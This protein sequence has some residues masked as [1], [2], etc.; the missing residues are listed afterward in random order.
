MDEPFGALDAQTRIMMQEN[1]LN[2]W[3]EFGTTVV[4]VTHDVDEAVFL[5]D[6]ILIMSASPGHVISDLPNRVPRPR[7]QSV[8]TNQDY[9]ELKLKCLETIRTESMLAFESQND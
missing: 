7:F 1:L 9:N 2:I 8:V 5:S 4:F 6:R 3:R